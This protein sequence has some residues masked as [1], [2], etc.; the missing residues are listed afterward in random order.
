[1]PPSHPLFLC[2]KSHG[3]LPPV[4][5]LDAAQLFGLT[6]PFKFNGYNAPNS[7][8]MMLRVSL[9]PRRVLIINLLLVPNFHQPVEL[10]IHHCLGVFLV[11]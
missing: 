4:S 10:F 5:M 2:L 1:M 8:A 9:S 3:S 11:E 6:H 7:W